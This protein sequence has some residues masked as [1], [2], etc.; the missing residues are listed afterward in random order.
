MKFIVLTDEEI[1]LLNLVLESQ[2][3]VLQK[4]VDKGIEVD[5][6]PPYITRIKELKE[7]INKKVVV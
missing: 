7:K 2:A 6:W 4:R 1:E 3:K 5:F